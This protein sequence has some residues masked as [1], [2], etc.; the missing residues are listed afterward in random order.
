MVLCSG[1][2]DNRIQEELHYWVLLA[3][4][5]ICSLD[6]KAHHDNISESQ[7]SLVL[8]MYQKLPNIL[9]VLLLV[10]LLLQP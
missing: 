1:H 7:V 9:M 8:E 4:P 5:T 6:H 10:F 2:F 3:V